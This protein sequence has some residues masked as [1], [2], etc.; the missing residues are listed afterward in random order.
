MMR[1]IAS[2][3]VLFF[4]F[5][6]GQEKKPA[7]AKLDENRIRKRLEEVQ[8]PALVMENDDINAY[9]KSHGLNMQTTGAG[10]RYQVTKENKKGKGI[11][12]KDIVTV[13]FKVS[14]LDGKLC[15]TSDSLGSREFI[16][17]HDHI[18][19]GIHQGIKLLRT[20]EKA[21]FILPSHLAH[22]LMGDQ[23][24]IPPKAAVVYEIEVLSVK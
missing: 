15:Y 7:E 17:D 14:L 9:I 12:T 6:C 1:R 24:R 23:K 2:I 19:N 10:L 22:G 20:G 18:E 13:N 4:L 21:I 3:S 16:V 5:S 11:L 8:K